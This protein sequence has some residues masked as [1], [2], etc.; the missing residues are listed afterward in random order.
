LSSN[1]PLPLLAD[2]LPDLATALQRL[3]QRQGFTELADSV[4][5]L[6]IHGCDGPIYFVPPGSIKRP[7]P[8]R[9]GADDTSKW[10]YMYH[11]GRKRH[12]LGRV[13]RRRWTLVVEEIDGRV[14]VLLVDDAAGA[15]GI[16]S[17]PPEAVDL[18]GQIGRGPVARP[19]HCLGS[20]ADQAT[21]APRF[22]AVRIRERA[23]LP[24]G[25]LPALGLSACL[26]WICFARA[27]CA[28]WISWRALSTSLSP[29]T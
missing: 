24:E 25:L 4:P 11:P 21:F 17:P 5:A 10:H 6:R 19:S 22:P 12:W 14:A 2:E 16:S 20:W 1:R 3:L 23:R 29:T 27:T 28:A 15:L 9:H 7:P 18:G 13:P 26:A 8:I